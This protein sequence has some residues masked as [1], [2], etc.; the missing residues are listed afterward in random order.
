[1]SIERALVQVRMPRM[2]IEELDEILDI[3]HDQLKMSIDTDAKNR[4]VQLSQGLPHYTHLLGLHSA[5]SS[6]QNG[7]T[8]I[9]ASDVDAAIKQ[10]IEKAQQT[11]I[12]AY[13][14]AITSPRKTLFPQ[15]LLS[16]ALAKKDPLGTFAASD[17]RD[18]MSLIMGERYD[19]PAFAR[20]LNDFCETR[21]GPVLQQLGSA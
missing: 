4:I 16:C 15:V 6:I 13:N 20:H 21:R 8:V 1:M 14:A 5:E 12:S 11:I 9:N 2:S 10:A 18:P 19:I 7:R 3:A 17:V